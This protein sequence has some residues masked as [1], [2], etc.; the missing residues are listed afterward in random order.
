LVGEIAEVREAIGPGAPGKVFVH[1]E[2][3]RAV[4]TDALKA[5]ARAKITSVRGLEIEVRA[6]P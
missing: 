1:G 6:I 5:G 3:W 4:S 2:I